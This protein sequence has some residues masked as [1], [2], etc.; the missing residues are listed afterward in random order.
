[1]FSNPSEPIRRIRRIRFNSMGEGVPIT[2]LG[3]QVFLRYRMALLPIAEQEH[4]TAQR[5]C[6]IPGLG[7][8]CARASRNQLGTQ[9]AIASL[10]SNQ[11]YGPRGVLVEN[12][13]H[14]R[15]EEVGGRQHLPESISQKIQ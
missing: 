15:M 12:A 3:S 7:K 1:M 8:K 11:R 9:S 14:E 6:G 2:A 10:R 5:G 13:A 4:K